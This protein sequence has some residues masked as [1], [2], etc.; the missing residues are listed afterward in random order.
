MKSLAWLIAA[1][2]FVAG[3]ADIAAPDS[4]LGLRS[5][6]ATQMGLLVV[7]VIRVVIG[8]VLIMA[9]P[10]TRAPRLFQIGG[11]VLL[12]AGLVT[13]LFGVERTKAVLDWE[14]MQGPLL[15]RAVGVLV[16]AIGATLA[17]ALTP[18]KTAA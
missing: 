9:A 6:I 14:A 11:A 16:I 8:V 13:P 17:F 12:L 18:R 4:V 5:F 1:F 3:I 2:V 10:S 15:I 7:S